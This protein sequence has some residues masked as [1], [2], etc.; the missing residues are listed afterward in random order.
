MRLKSTRLPRWS[1]PAWFCLLLAAAPLLF[2]ACGGS[3]PV[4]SGAAATPTPTLIVQTPT[5]VPTPTIAQPTLT[6]AAGST[7]VVQI[8]DESNGSFGFTPAALEIR[9]GTTV[10]WKNMSSVPHTVTSDDGTTFDSGTLAVGGT[11]RFTFKTAGTFSYHCN[12]HPYMRSVIIV[13]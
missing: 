11:F 6:P 8:S 1:V 4:S 2:S 10:A 12:V 5:P 9:V 7:Q 3:T 13:V